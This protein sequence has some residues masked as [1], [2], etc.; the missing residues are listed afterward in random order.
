MNKTILI[1]VMATLCL[2]LRVTAQH[3][4]PKT[5]VNPPIKPL[6][7][8][9]R[10]PEVMLTNLH[11]YKTTSINLADFEAKLIIIDFWATWCSPCV[12]M[13][14]KI[15]SLQKEFKHDVQFISVSYQTAQE[16]TS[17]MEKLEKHKNVHY[18]VPYS[19][20]DNLL[21]FM[22]PHKT[23]PH[24]V[25][26]SANGTVKAITGLEELTAANI[27]KMMASDSYTLPEK[28]DVR[29]PYDFNKPFLVNGNGGDGKQLIYHSVL[30]GFIPGLSST[31]KAERGD[32][33]HVNRLVLTNCPLLWLYKHA[34]GN[35]YTTYF[36]QNRIV[37]EVDKPDELNS[38]L[39]G[40]AFRN[41]LSMPNH[42][43]CYEL[44]LPTK[45]SAQFY[46]VMQ[47]NLALLFPQYTARIEKRKV[48]YMALIRLPGADKI[49]S[50]HLN[51]KVI[52]T[53]DPFGFKVQNSTIQ[54]I[55]S[56]M[57]LQY[58]QFSA[59][60]FM[61][62][63][64]YQGRVDLEITA[65]LSSVTDMNKALMPYNL[66]WQE[67]LADQDMLVITDTKKIN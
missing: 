28:K 63:T 53:F 66:A 33:V 49:K 26:I 35:G 51:G 4:V 37:L 48:K 42:G 50:S 44:Q 15:D 41:W 61:D 29:L 60:P 59:F 12:S 13:I 19:T 9:Q 11:N 62:E 3:T 5:K 55:V 14:P 25:W 18:S 16:V 64:G 39:T 52:E 67:R 10:M 36:Q 23:L 31:M 54:S 17:F 40:K 21:R 27:D 8:G 56:R 38:M 45:L 57:Q 22:F 6:H 47:Q 43:V 1:I 58:Q 20:D 24:Y 32:S 46:P 7:I 34:Y 30:S 65:N 2:F